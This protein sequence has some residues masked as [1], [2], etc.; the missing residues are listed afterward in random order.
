[1]SN[2][3]TPGA[4]MIA[5]LVRN[6]PSTRPLAIGIGAPNP[7]LVSGREFLVESL[8]VALEKYR[9]GKPARAA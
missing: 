5:T 7:R 6:G 4:G 1:T 2:L 3:A 8:M 9:S